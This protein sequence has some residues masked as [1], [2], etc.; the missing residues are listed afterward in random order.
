MPRKY[1]NKTAICTYS[2]IVLSSASFCVQ[3]AYEGWI[4]K[5]WEPLLSPIGVIGIILAVGAVVLFVWNIRRDEL[6]PT[7]KADK[8]RG[9]LPLLNQLKVDIVAYVSTS[10]LVS[11]DEILNS[12]ASY[13]LGC[14]HNVLRFSALARD[15]VM[16]LELM[17]RQLGDLREEIDQLTKQIQND[18]LRKLLLKA[19]QDDYRSKSQLIAI[20]LYR[21]QHPHTN[22]NELHLRKSEV[23]LLTPNRVKV[24]DRTLNKLYRHIDY[25]NRGRD[26]DDNL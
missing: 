21:S 13:G 24:F 15:N 6:S 11:K 12:P 16:L 5:G 10:N 14:Q 26:I 18:K 17:S 22:G 25:L 7:E 9:R 23:K 8:Y 19:F 4:M 2:A 1:R 3:F 20:R